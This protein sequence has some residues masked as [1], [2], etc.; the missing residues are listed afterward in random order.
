M[1]PPDNGQVGALTLV[2]YSEVFFIGEGGRGGGLR[3]VCTSASIPFE[4]AS[5]PFAHRFNGVVGGVGSKCV[6]TLIIIPPFCVSYLA[7]N[8]QRR[9]GNLCR[10]E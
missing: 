4:V 5:I 6:H 9:R 7:K 10:L 8:S 3:H 1:E 2:H